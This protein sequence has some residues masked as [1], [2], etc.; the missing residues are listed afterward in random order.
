MEGSG[1][2]TFVMDITGEVNEATLQV[3]KGVVGG[4]E[5][6]VEQAREVLAKQGEGAVR[7]VR[8]DDAQ[9][10]DSGHRMPAGII[11]ASLK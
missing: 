2:E 1:D 11:E 4:I 8:R 9:G 5:I 10:F 7:E 6:A 3:G